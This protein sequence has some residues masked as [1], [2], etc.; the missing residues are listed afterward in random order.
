M[1]RRKVGTG[2]Q[3]VGTGRTIRKRIEAERKERKTT[4]G[5][6][7]GVVC[8]WKLFLCNWPLHRMLALKGFLIRIKDNTQL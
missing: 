4:L 6:C 3:V 7:L 1:T 5:K 2:R 8:C